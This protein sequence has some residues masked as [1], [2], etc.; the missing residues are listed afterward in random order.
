MK[1]ISLSF[2][3]VLAYLLTPVKLEKCNNEV[4]CPDSCPSCTTCVGN[5]TLDELCCEE[6]ILASNKYCDVNDAPCILESD[7][8]NTNTNDTNTDEN[9]DNR[10]DT[11]DFIEGLKDFFT[12][13]PN[14]ILISIL[15]PLVLSAIYACTCFDRRKPPLD[16]DQIEWRKGTSWVN[17]GEQ[18]SSTENNTISK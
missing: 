5:F 14:I 8:N 4:C 13:I 9:N 1:Y 7:K 11:D 12:Q 17:T 2:V 6:I 10:N 3:L 16:Y 15:V 18:L